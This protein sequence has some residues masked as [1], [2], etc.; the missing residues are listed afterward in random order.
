MSS[1]SVFSAGKKKN[2]LKSSVCLSFCGGLCWEPASLFA[3]FPIYRARVRG[4]ELWKTPIDRAAGAD[5][6]GSGE[7]KSEMSQK[8]G[9]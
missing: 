9:L 7:K 4:S 1:E 8:D 3:Q 2:H 5:D 6:A